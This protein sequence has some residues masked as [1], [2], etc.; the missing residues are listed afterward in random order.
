MAQAAEAAGRAKGRILTPPHKTILPHS[1]RRLKTP[2]LRRH[3]QHASRA[4]SGASHAIH[5]PAIADVDGANQQPGQF[6]SIGFGG[7]CGKQ[8]GDGGTAATTSTSWWSGSTSLFGTTVS[9]ST[10]AIGA[11]LAAVALWAAFKKK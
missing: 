7:R 6:H 9:N 11:G 5:R 8:F 1:T 3:H 4:T 2:R 10:L